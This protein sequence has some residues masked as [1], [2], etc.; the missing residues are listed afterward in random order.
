MTSLI[1]NRVKGSGEWIESLLLTVKQLMNWVLTSREGEWMLSIDSPLSLLSL[2]VTVH[3]VNEQIPLLK[4]NQVQEQEFIHKIGSPGIEVQVQELLIN[5]V[6]LQSPFFHSLIF[7]SPVNKGW[8]NYFS[9]IWFWFLH[10][11][12]RLS[13]LGNIGSR[14]SR[15]A[16]SLRGAVQPYESPVF[17]FFFFLVQSGEGAKPLYRQWK[18]G[19]KRAEVKENE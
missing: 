9:F 1:G 19:A 5:L 16:D 10:S 2:S 18:K 7:S 8:L 11:F 14:V 3:Q 13:S 4:W 17:L 6:L 15:E 12:T